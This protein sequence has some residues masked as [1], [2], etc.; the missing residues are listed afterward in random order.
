MAHSKDHCRIAGY[1]KNR[2][3][4]MLESR[5]HDKSPAKKILRRKWSV[6]PQVSP[7]LV[8]F[9]VDCSRWSGIVLYL[10]YK[11]VRQ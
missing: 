1:L 9:G 6:G 10:N 11:A 7:A 8:L 5:L 2:W 4:E 3:K